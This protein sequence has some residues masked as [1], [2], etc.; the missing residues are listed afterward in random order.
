MDTRIIKTQPDKTKALIEMFIAF[1]I[2]Y[3]LKEQNTDENIFFQRKPPI[4][5]RTNKS[6][7]QNFR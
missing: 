7:C 6:H 5:T 4:Y 2:A 1:D 3:Q